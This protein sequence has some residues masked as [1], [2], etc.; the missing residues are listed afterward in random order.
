MGNPLTSE[1]LDIKPFLHEGQISSA[2]SFRTFAD[3]VIAPA[4]HE[5]DRNQVTPAELIAEIGRNG[6]LGAMLDPQL[7][8]RGLD[9]ITYGLLSEELGRTCQNVRNLVAVV[10]MVAQSIATWGTDEQRERWLA[11]IASGRSVAAFA[12]TEPGVGSD[13][14][15]VTTTARDDGASI[16][17]DGH[18]K[19]ISYAEIADVYLV[20]AQY[21]GQ[22]T[23]FLVERDTPG[24]EVVPIRGM[25]GLRGSMLAELLFEECRISKDAILARPGAGLAFVASSALD[26]GR[27]ST[28]WGC[29][30][31]I[32][33]CLDG[34]SAYAGRRVQYDVTIKNHQLVQ[35]M[36][37]DMVADVSAARLL[38]LSAGAAHS[39][40]NPNAISQTLT[41]KF[42][43]S[44][45]ACRATADAVQI[46][47]AQGISDQAP[48]ERYYRDAKVMEIIEGTTQLHQSMLGGAVG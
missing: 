9:R 35:G 33:A 22:H 25:M 14:K 48:V 28:A 21:Q 7:G 6:H 34:S 39:E 41:A 13:A 40:K 31:L 2:K 44:R 20:F 46:H 32:Q 12:L 30:G 29:V 36:L 4:A 27:Y 24:L 42:F 18:K 11:R 47:G 23:A 1:R 38:C 43:A 45:A 8:G 17:L 37:A 10:D 5:I 19:W 15:S 3:E 16:V 26:I